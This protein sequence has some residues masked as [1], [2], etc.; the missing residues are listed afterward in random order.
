MPFPVSSF[1]HPAPGSQLADTRPPSA[2]TRP[3]S[4]P[5]S[6]TREAF[7]DFVA[8]TFYGQMLKAL[9]ST[10]DKP[11]YLHGGRA[12]DMFRAQLDQQISEQLARDH[13]AALADPLFQ[14]FARPRVATRARPMSPTAAAATP[15]APAETAPATGTARAE[16]PASIR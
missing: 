16:S 2:L 8:G 3:Q 7:Q 6:E 9:R 14:S 1:T 10:Q 4:A 12:E 15:A 13:G 5:A 11:K